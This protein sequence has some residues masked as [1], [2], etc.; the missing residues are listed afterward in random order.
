MKGAHLCNGTLLFYFLVM[1]KIN[2][3]LITLF[4]LVLGCG[5][6]DSP[7]IINPKPDVEIKWT[8]VPEAINFSAK[9]GSENVIVNANGDWNVTSDKDWCSV[10]LVKGYNG[11]TGLKI[12]ASANP[13]ES[14][15]NAQLSFVSG[16]YSHQY[17]ITQQAGKIDEFVPNGYTLKWQDEF[18][19]EKKDGDKPILPNTEKWWYENLPKGA[20]NNELQ[21]YVGGFSGKDTVAYISNGTLKIVAKKQGSEVISARI[22][23]KES[24]KYGYFESRLKVPKG[25]GTWPAFWMMPQDFKN[26][27]LDGEIDIMEYVGYDPNVVHSSVH[28]QAYYHTIGTQKTATKRITN[29]EIEFH[30]YAVEWTADKIVGFVDGVAYFTFE[31]DGK[32]N[33]NTWPFNKPFYL[34]LNLAWGGDWGGA[35]GV[36]DNALPATFEIDYVRVYQK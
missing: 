16:K 26:W 18:N 36:D 6:K 11:Q 14:E 2:T 24:W 19:N 35:Q 27:P 25:K 21:T 8:I 28:T 31:N 34:K 13:I 5:S 15:R 32:N 22:N 33:V 10:S 29:A 7:L 12:T 23:T 9:G 3:I 4:F 17:K 20:V 1:K 30:I